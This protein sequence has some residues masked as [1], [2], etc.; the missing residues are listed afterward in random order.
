MNCIEH[1]KELL[2]SYGKE[3]EEL[4]NRF[5]T[6]VTKDKKKYSETDIN[7]AFTGKSNK[8]VDR[9]KGF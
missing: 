3:L 8:K 4:N 5:I 7:F 2:D 6:K 1:D 9:R